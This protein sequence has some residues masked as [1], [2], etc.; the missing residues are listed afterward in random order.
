MSL[1]LDDVLAEPGLARTADEK[2]RHTYSPFPL[3]ETG[4]TTTG[5]A[6]DRRCGLGEFQQARHR[7]SYQG[8]FRIASSWPYEQESGGIRLRPP[9]GGREWIVLHSAV[10]QF[11]DRS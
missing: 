3:R 9:E 11:W 8:R 10:R 6:L 5:L 4:L 7:V 1:S 2:V